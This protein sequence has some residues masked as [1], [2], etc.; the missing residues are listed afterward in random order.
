MMTPLT[1][2]QWTVIACE[3]DGQKI[4]DDKMKTVT[5]KGNTVTWTHD[6][7]QCTAR[8]EFGPHN[9]VRAIELNTG[10]SASTTGS[11]GA[12]GTTDRTGAA[13]TQDRK[14]TTNRTG[15]GGQ[16][17][18][19]TTG[20]ATS[21]KGGFDGT[22]QG[23]AHGVYV[24]SHDFVALS[25]VD[26]SGHGASGVRQTSGSDR[27]GYSERYFTYSIEWS[28]AARRRFLSYVGHACWDQ[29]TARRA[30]GSSRCLG[31]GVLERVHRSTWQ[32]PARV[33]LLSP[34]GLCTGYPSRR[35]HQGKKR[36]WHL[37]RGLA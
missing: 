7:K 16:G 22:N 32:W 34:P 31:A 17:T 5:I 6:G 13:G 36:P 20:A 37:A 11:T 10:G 4:T 35:A 25:L 9:T 29:G 27:T 28:F 2:G 14:D 12:S 3:I 24:A 33:P 19:G 15:T 30:H 26:T 1:D 23:V 21:G 18:S 8:L